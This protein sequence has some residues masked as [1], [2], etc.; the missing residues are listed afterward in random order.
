[1]V[2]NK[3]VAELSSKMT[4]GSKKDIGTERIRQATPKAKIS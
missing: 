3:A 4:S 2:E 1:M